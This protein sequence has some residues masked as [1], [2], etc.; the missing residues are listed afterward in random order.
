MCG[1]VGGEWGWVGVLRKGWGSLSW[2]VALL[3]VVRGW[4]VLCFAGDSVSFPC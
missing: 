3:V 1:D 2:M 4:P